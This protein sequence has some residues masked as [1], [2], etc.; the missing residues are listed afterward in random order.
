MRRNGFRAEV[1][2]SGAFPYHYTIRA[3]AQPQT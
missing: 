2:D 1:V 3:S